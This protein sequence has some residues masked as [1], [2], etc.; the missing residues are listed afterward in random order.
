MA[1][2]IRVEDRHFSAIGLT[3]AKPALIRSVGDRITAAL[4]GALAL[5]A[6]ASQLAPLLALL[7]ASATLAWGMIEWCSAA[8]A[9]VQGPGGRWVDWIPA[10]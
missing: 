1:V 6:V 9:Q 8:A 10:R 7:L 3:A 2:S 5:L 4:P